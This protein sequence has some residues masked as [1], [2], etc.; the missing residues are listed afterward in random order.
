MKDIVLYNILIDGSNK[1][2]KPNLALDLFDELLLKGLKPTVR[3]YTVMISV[4]CQGGL[5]GKAN[6]LLRKME[7]NGCLPDSVM[8]NVIVQELLKKS[9]CQEAEN[10]LEEMIN[11]GFMPDS[12]TFTMVLHLIPNVGKE[13]RMRTIIQKQTTVERKDGRILN[14]TSRLVP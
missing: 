11:R 9:K 5:F 7:D 3:T 10:F 14:L 12:T 4:Y 2:G 6:D 1:C 8:Y 13:S